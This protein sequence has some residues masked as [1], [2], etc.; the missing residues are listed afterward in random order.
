M[1][2]AIG[3]VFDIRAGKYAAV[4]LSRHAPTL[5]WLYGLYDRCILF[6]Q[7]DQLRVGRGRGIAPPSRVIAG[8]FQRFFFH[9]SH[10]LLLVLGSVIIPETMKYTV[11]Q[12]IAKLAADGMP[13]S[14]RLRKRHAHPR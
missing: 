5:K 7:R 11:R 9:G 6:R 1:V 2:I 8:Q 13:V 3:G 4:F 12:E 14:L 10:L